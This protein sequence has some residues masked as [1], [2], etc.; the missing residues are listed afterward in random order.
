[1]KKKLLLLSQQHIY[2]YIYIYICCWDIA[3]H[4]NSLEHSILNANVSV[5]T[6][7]I[8]DT[9]IKT[10]EERLIYW[11]IYAFMVYK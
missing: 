11:F 5:V 7:W 3:A 8:N 6:S 1:M 10:E 4:F 9:N 2:I